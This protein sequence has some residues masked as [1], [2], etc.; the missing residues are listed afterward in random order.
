MNRILEI[1]DAL[2]E[3]APISARGLLH[4]G[5]RAAIDQTLSRLV[6]RGA[7]LRAGR[8]LYVRPVQTRFGVR[9]PAPTAVLAQLAAETGEVIVSTGAAAAN[10]LGL[11]TQVPM[12]EMYF[13]SGPTRR[14]Q[15][16][17]QIVE[18]RH[19]PRWQLSGRQAGEAVRA[20]HWLGPTHGASGIAQLA[21]TLPKPDVKEL[22]DLRSRLPTWLAREVSALAAHG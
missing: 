6:R 19:A 9:P 13:T 5:S 8:G 16:G 3:G 12:R 11:T 22:L 10:A 15:L 4:L 20:L 18:L 1:A 17:A 21:R 7:L 2:P 14:L